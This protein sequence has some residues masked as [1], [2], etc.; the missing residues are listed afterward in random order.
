[1]PDPFRNRQIAERCIGHH[2][3]ANAVGEITRTPGKRCD[4]VRRGAPRRRTVIVA[5][6]APIGTARFV[7]RCCG[8]R[9]A[10]GEPDR[11]IGSRV[12]GDPS[13]Q[14]RGSSGCICSLSKTRG[15]SSV[16]R[17]S[18]RSAGL[19]R[20]RP[21]SFSEISESEPKACASRSTKN[22]KIR[23][24]GEGTSSDIFRPLLDYSRLRERPTHTAR[25]TIPTRCDFRASTTT[26]PA[27]IAADGESSM[28]YSPGRSDNRAA[29]KLS[30]HKHIECV[31]MHESVTSCDAFTLRHAKRKPRNKGF[32]ARSCHRT[33]T[34]R[35][36][37]RGL[38]RTPNPFKFGVRDM[39]INS[40]SGDESHFHESKVRRGCMPHLMTN[41]TMA[42]R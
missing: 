6:H 15:A 3:I 25:D 24:S 28:D 12:R 30:T 35:R 20:G 31:Q 8:H 2:L 33:D 21:H 26:A 1:V 42:L 5:T 17:R 41:I 18:L 38:A 32:F 19:E 40:E 23:S 34:M 22:R 7:V 37:D 16:V 10:A 11:W 9:R 27:A 29:G 36:R 39:Y 13:R 14:R 4:R